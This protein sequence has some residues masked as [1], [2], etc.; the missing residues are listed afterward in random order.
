M[1]DSIDTVDAGTPSRLSFQS[2]NAAVPTPR[3]PVTVSPAVVAAH[4]DLIE[5]LAVEVPHGIVG[6]A[7]DRFDIL[8][9]AEHLKA[10]LAAVAGYAQAIV[11]DTAD[12]SPVN[13][14]DETAGLED[15]AVGIVGALLEANDRLQGLQAAA[16]E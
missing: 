9:R 12:Y 7:A 11:K 3:R 8:E 16:D 2:I 14:L 13:I 15:T 4:R 6:C 10:V 1:V 5:A